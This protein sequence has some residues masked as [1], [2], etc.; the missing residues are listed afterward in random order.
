MAYWIIG[1]RFPVPRVRQRDKALVSFI[2]LVIAATALAQGPS[3]AIQVQGIVLSGRTPLPGTVIAAVN[4]ETRTAFTT[5][6]DVNG[7]YSLKLPVVGKYEISADITAFAPEKKE[8]EI[9]DATKP[10][11]LD[12]EMTLLSRSQPAVQQAARGA[13]GARRGSA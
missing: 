7:Q 9:T 11:R 3:A 8:I 13:R 1:W 6:T 10:T 2:L 12:F 5:S 4:S